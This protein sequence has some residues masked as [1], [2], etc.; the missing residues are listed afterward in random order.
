MRFAF[1]DLDPC[2]SS[3]YGE[4]LAA[5]FGRGEAT[6]IEG[7]GHYVQIDAPEAVAEQI[8]SVPTV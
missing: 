2:L 7:V 6:T 3:A 1:G 5:M 4:A 8:L